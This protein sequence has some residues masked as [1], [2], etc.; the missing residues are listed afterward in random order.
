MAL[1]DDEAIYRI[2]LNV[3]YSI[4]LDRGNLN[5]KTSLMLVR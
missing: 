2:C 1:A 5:Q 4:S 3:E